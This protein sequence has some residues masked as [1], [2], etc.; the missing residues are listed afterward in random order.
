MLTSYP[1][2]LK[3]F[4][5]VGLHRYFLTFCTLDRRALFVTHERVEIVLAQFLRSAAEN[6]F[7]LVAYCIMPDHV[8]LLIEAQSEASDGRRFI[9]RAKQYSGYYFKQRFGTPVWQRYGY[10][11][12]LR[13]DEATL[14]VA[15]YILENPVR[16]RLVERVEDYPFLGSMVYSVREIL[17]AV[18]L[19]KATRKSG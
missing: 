6:D 9:N 14:S 15:R 3:A 7:R 11:H 1:T 18:Q 10:E 19:M 16:A 5:Y 17:E 2:H 8:H 4:D 13:D 12:V